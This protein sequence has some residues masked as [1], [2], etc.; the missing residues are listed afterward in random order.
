M[1]EISAET[2]KQ[3]QELAKRR[4]VSVDELL[5]DF[6]KDTKSELKAT[7]QKAL[8]QLEN[9]EFTRLNNKAEIDAHFDNMLKRYKNAVDA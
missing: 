1:I 6:V 4:H 8:I 3:L 7:I 2:E 5:A 9:G